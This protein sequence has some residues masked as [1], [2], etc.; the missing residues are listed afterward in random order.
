MQDFTI[1]QI[2]WKFINEEKRINVAAKSYVII[3]R[4][5]FLFGGFSSIK[6][7][8]LKISVSGGKT[9]RN[10]LLLSISRYNAQTSYSFEAYNAT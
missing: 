4:G 6:K 8:G 7:I 5:L 10:F 1:L 9:T 2:K 3:D